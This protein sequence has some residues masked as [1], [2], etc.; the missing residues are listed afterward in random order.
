MA[1]AQGARAQMAFGFETTY[2]IP[3]AANKY[4][5]MPFATSSLGAEQPLLAS[6]L[7]GYGRDPLPPNRDAI[8]ADGDVVVPINPRHWG[9]WLKAAF[10]D[11]VTV[12]LV[13]ASGFILFAAQPAVGST[14]T[15]NGTVFTFVASGATAVQ[16]NIGAN[17]GATLTNIV[18]ALNASVVPAVALATYAQTGGNTL[19]VTADA[20]GIT[21]NA[22]TLAASAAPASNGT[23]SGATLTGGANSHTFQSGNWTLPSFSIETFMPDVPYS[24][25][26]RGCVL[27]TLSWSMQR[28]GM[29]NATASIVA[30]TETIGTA[31]A[32]GTLNT[33]PLSRFSQF[34]G[35]ILRGGAQIGSIIGAQITYANNLDRIDAIRGDGLIDGADPSMAMLSGTLDVRFADQTL[36][37]QATNGTP[38]E[39]QFSYQ[40][41]ASS[42]FRFTAHAVYLPRPKFQLQGPGGVQAQ[43]SWQ[44]ARD[45]TLGR[46]CTAVLVNDLAT[47]NNP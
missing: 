38:A 32:V 8:T 2:G 15:V 26:M 13:V 37:A 20:I 25:M 16:I 4:W 47:F 33:F 43:F 31:S 35:G 1:R 30:Q 28:S 11:P 10:G 45:L 29:A 27:D 22:I 9:V 42:F 46:L 3:I 12:P 39:F 23:V 34:Q 44:A 14:L 6:E 21:G 5:Q 17:L 24:G 19:T 7:L 41:D 18:T 40:I 36:L